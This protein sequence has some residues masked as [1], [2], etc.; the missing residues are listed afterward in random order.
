MDLTTNH[1]FTIN[2]FFT[3]S[4]RNAPTTSHCYVLDKISVTCDLFFFFRENLSASTT[5]WWIRA[6]LVNIGEFILQL[7]LIPVL[8]IYL[9]T[10]S[11]AWWARNCQKTTQAVVDLNQR[12]RKDCKCKQ[13][14]L[15]RYWKIVTSV[16]FHWKA[17]IAIFCHEMYTLDAKSFIVLS[18]CFHV[19][20][21]E[22]NRL[23]KLNLSNKMLKFLAKF[24]TVYLGILHSL[25]D[26]KIVKPINYAWRRLSCTVLCLACTHYILLQ[27]CSFV[28]NICN[29]WVSSWKQLLNKIITIP[30]LWYR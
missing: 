29:M 20:L 12:F 1:L 18:L 13:S 8:L 22:L 26:K 28:K 16:M 21:L 2:Q 6:L 11:S 25:Y 10:S 30:A 15:K 23:I 5:V 3:Q 7:Y 4:V 27:N 14:V 17:I 9:C 19:L 24:V